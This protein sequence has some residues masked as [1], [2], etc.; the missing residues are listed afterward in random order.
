VSENGPVSSATTENVEVTVRSVFLPDQS[1]AAQSRYAFAY[2]VKIANHGEL[3]VQL[4]SRHWI[5]IDGVG[6]RQEVRGEGVVG[7]QPKLAPGE[8]FEYTSGCVL[9]TPHGAMHGTYQ[10]IRGDGRRFNAE[11]ATFSLAAPNSLN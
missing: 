3:P 5:I 8:Q 1:S 11:I 7:E 10:M 2:H 4:R 6:E 9:K